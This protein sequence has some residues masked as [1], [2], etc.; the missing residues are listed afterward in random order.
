MELELIRIS[1]HNVLTQYPN[2]TAEEAAMVRQRRELTL[3]LPPAEAYTLCLRSLET[4][5]NCMLP[6]QNAA[7]GR[8][9]AR[10]GVSWRSWGDEIAFQLYSEEGTST[11]VEITSRPVVR[12]TLVDFGKNLENVEKIAEFLR[13]HG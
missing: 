2:V 4:I 6:T 3:P 9:T 1:I 7:V 11:R 13:Q 8:I 5:P 10:T 12:T